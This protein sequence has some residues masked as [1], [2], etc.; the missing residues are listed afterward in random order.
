MGKHN[1]SKNFT[2]IFSSILILLGASDNSANALSI[3][4]N[5][6]FSSDEFRITE[7]ASNLNYPSGI[8]QLSD[9]SLVVGI[10]Q[11]ERGFFN[12]TGQLLRLMDTN[13][14][15]IAESN[16]QQVLFNGL[17]GGITSIKQAGDL[18]FVSSFNKPTE[19]ITVLRQGTKVDDSF[20][21][22]G[23]INFDFAEQRQHA[24]T[25]LAIRNN[26]QGNKNKY[27]LFFNVG[28][29][30]NNAATVDPINLNSSE[31]LL[32]GSNFNVP[33]DGDSIYKITVDTASAT[34]T[35]SDLTKVATGLRNASALD[36]Q[37]NTGDLYIAENGIDGLTNSNEPLSAD[38]LNS[39]PNDD[40]DSN[41]ENFGFPDNNIEYRTG[42]LIDG[43]G[44]IIK[45]INDTNQPLVAFQ[46]IPDA[47]NG[48]ESEGPAAIAFAPSQFPA[49]LND[50]MFVAFFG[51]FGKAGINNEEN[52]LVYVNLETGEYFH[53]ISNQEPSIGHITSLLSNEDSLFL[54]DLASSGNLFDNSATGTI[55]QIQAVSAAVPFEFSP[56][57]GIILASILLGSNHL[58]KAGKKYLN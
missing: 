3:S 21:F 24:S 36:F 45:N 11:G 22:V 32:N 41:V 50:G 48:F 37:E 29:E 30:N 12:S 15:G 5:S 58:F 7:F 35:F 54:V 52:P 46:P 42:D 4:D 49:T 53:F 18:F 2:L 57:L 38:E 40:I 34:P 9:G 56:G 19:S 17:P 27:D 23:R 43:N 14:D 13:Q 1:L 25:A 26:S 16:N 55:Y 44:N 8:T 33:L 39:I 51:R 31:F 6:T 28:S 47:L 10:N 20:D